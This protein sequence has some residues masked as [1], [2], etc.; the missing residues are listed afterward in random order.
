MNN[1]FNKSNLL[2][3]LGQ[4]LR[5]RLDA[6]ND[7]PDMSFL[8]NGYEAGLN[9]E[10][11]QGIPIDDYSLSADISNWF[12]GN[13]DKIRDL[14]ENYYTNYMLGYNEYLDNTRYQRAMKDLMDAGLNPYL[15]LT[16][17]SASPASGGS[18]NVSESSQGN[19]KSDRNFDLIS[20]ILKTLGAVAIFGKLFG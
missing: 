14:Y 20:M 12:S 18:Y 4:N 17:G 10:G 5:D 8:A 1:I 7:L 9:N 2:Q 13:Y 15:L 3:E 16:G 11:L 6:K 19:F